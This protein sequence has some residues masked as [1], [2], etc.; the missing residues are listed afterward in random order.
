MIVDLLNNNNLKKAK[1]S[2]NFTILSNESDS[3]DGH[4][5]YGAGLIN[6]DH[7][8]PL[9][10]NIDEQ[11]AFVDMGALHARADVEKRVK[12]IPT[13]EDVPTEGM[14]RYWLI[15]ITIDTKDKKPY[16]SGI[17][18]CYM[19]VNKAAKRGYKSMPE[20]V[21]QMDKAL[22]GKVSVEK[23]DEPSRQVLAD[24]LKAH[25]E[26]IWN[27]STTLHEALKV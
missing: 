14:K 13:L 2:S 3:T 1:K 23:M 7:M 26:D 20:H 17:G 5:G 24:F 22:K 21:N 9:F 15:W 8:T 18:A 25:S 6:L 27:E 19:T 12:F 4:G 16:Y 10:I 11:E